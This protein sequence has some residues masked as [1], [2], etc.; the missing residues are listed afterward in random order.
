MLLRVHRGKQQRSHCCRHH[1][2]AATVAAVA[3]LQTLDEVLVLCKKLGIRVILSLADYQGSLGAGQNGFEPY[4]MWVKGTVN[5]TGGLALGAWVHAM[6][7]RLG[8]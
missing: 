1:L 5:I 7:V 3:A 8:M 4:L 2:A 6:C